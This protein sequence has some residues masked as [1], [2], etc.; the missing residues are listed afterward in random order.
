MNNPQSS[1]VTVRV[2]ITDANDNSP[3][4]ENDPIIIPVNEATE[5]GTSVYNFTALDA[6]SGSNGEIRYDLIKHFP[7]ASSFTVDALT[8]TLTLTSKL[9]YETLPEYTLIVR[10]TDQ[11][12]NSSERLST[13]VTA[14]IIVTD[15]NDNSPKFV[16]PITPNVILSDSLTVGMVITHIIAF[17]SDSGN[18]GRVTYVISGGNEAGKFSLG[19]D[20]G[21]LTL[22]KPLMSA[23][24]KGSYNLNITANDHGNPTKQA[25]MILKLSVRASAENPPRF[26]NSVY[27]VKLAEDAPTGSFVVKVA[28]KSAFLERG[29]FIS[30]L[31][32]A[33]LCL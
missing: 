12:V 10:A 14:R 30:F 23:G 7:N 17:D 15:S 11:S 4:W 3:K 19:Y 13:S 20:T 6:D 22:A 31:N 2:D 28:A 26:L 8:G 16:F 9:D 24:D 1:A 27:N 21:V 29:K 25:H 5:I 33:N 18:N 32:E